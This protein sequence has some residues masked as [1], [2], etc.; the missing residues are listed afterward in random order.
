MAVLMTLEVPGGTT[1]HVRPANEILGIAGEQDAP[2]GLIVHTCAVTDDGIVIVDVWHSL[3]SL[4]DFAHNRLA[5]AF[6]EAGMPG[7]RR[8]SHRARP[9]LRHRQQPNVLVL[10]HAPGLTAEAY[11]AIVARMPSHADGGESHPAVMHVAAAEPDGSPSP[12]S[13]TPRR[14]TWSSPRASCSR[15]SRTRAISFCASGRST[16]AS[17]P[18]PDVAA[19]ALKVELLRRAR[20]SLAAATRRQRATGHTIRVRKSAASSTMPALTM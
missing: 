4:D 11:D 10:L 12:A 9:D 14:R 6:A 19:E 15:R 17:A 3:S 2:P 13:G 1:A 8:T 18:A 7:P 20:A 16:T 5:A